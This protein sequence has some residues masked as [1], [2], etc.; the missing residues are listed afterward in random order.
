MLWVEKI[1]VV[2][3]PARPETNSHS[4]SRWRGSSPA[5]G[6][7][8]SRTAGRASSPIAMLIRCWLPPDSVPTWSSR[9][10]PSPVWSSISSTVA[11]TSATCSK[12][13]NRRRFSATVSRRYS[14]ACC[15]I[16]PI[17]PGRRLTVPSS[18]RRIPARIDSRVVLPAPL[19]PITASN[20]PR[21]ASK[22]KPRS[23][24]WPSKRLT[25][26]RPSITTCPSLGVR[27]DTLGDPLVAGYAA[28]MRVLF[29]G[30]VVGK[31]GRAGLSR[32][33]PELRER[34]S[35]DL[36]I[37]NGENAAGGIGITEKT[38]RELYD[39]GVDV[40]T[41]GNHV[42][43]HRDVYGFLD[44]TESV[45]RPANYM[46]GNPGRGHT[47]VSVAGRRVAVVNLRGVVELRAARSPFSEAD[48][49][50]ERVG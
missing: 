22:L 5:L 48:A 9:R 15:G 14:A 13:A 6:S 20:S 2:P 8:S 26:P 38:A 45:I 46:T 16:Q 35:P 40:L 3:P 42:Y 1:T 49:I 23:A 41:T 30:D 19:G 36:V 39:T 11:S 47:I 21:R 10:P 37:A 12:C 32:A 44:R 24:V 25:S 4:R 7:S 34:H 29:I 31:P 43:R 18:G 17:S 50:V 28:P 33:M 27:G